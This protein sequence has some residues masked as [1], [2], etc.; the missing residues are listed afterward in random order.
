MIASNRIAHSA[1]Q[2][3]WAAVLLLANS[4]AIGIVLLHRDAARA[5]VTAAQ[6]N[7]VTLPGVVPLAAPALP[8]GP[9]RLIVLHR[10]AGVMGAW[11]VDPQAGT[12]GKIT[13]DGQDV[14]LVSASPT[15]E[16]GHLP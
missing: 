11:L 7:A 6:A 2:W 8:A 1:R 9:P 15:G 3:T 4:L 5:E 16:L 12:A 13:A 14:S 10:T